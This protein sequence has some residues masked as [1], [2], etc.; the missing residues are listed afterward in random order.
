MY[1][2]GFRYQE[3]VISEEEEARLIATFA[4]LPFKE[5]QFGPFQGKR[6]VLS[7]GWRYDYTEQRAK[8]AE[9]ILPF[10]V[11]TY[12]TI[13]SATGFRL[14]NLEQALVTEYAPGTTIGWHRDKTMFQEVLGLSL[15]SL[16][17]FRLRKRTGDK[18]T[19][20]NLEALPRSAY[21][22]EGE[23]RWEWEHSIPPVEE[24]RYSITFRSLR[25]DFKRTSE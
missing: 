18:W 16:C 2:P 24:L 3:E 10:L 20:V 22:F 1:P 8:P 12:Q 19:R 7:F 15:S 25:D 4:T 9:P 14:S 23:A 17:N 6:R 5:F 13:R 11:D 21:F